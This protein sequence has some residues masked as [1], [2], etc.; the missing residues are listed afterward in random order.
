[1]IPRHFIITSLICVLQ[2]CATLALV[3][4]AS[5]DCIGAFA[6][7][8]LFAFITCI[9]CCSIVCLLITFFQF[10][11]WVFVRIAYLRHHPQYRDQRVAQLLRL[12]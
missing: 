11:D 7:Y 12:I 6:S 4:N 8:V 5:P 3:A 2:V 9:C 10:V 1:M